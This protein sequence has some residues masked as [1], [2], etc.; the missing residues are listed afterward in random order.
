MS[1]TVHTPESDDSAP[2][3]LLLRMVSEARADARAR[4]VT[5]LSRPNR[6]PHT[7]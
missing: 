6:D 2:V 7:A 1:D 4:G 3:A 5:T